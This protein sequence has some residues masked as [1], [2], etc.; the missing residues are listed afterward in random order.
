MSLIYSE[1]KI[2]LSNILSDEYFLKI[3]LFIRFITHT[4]P[5]AGHL[6]FIVFTY[7]LISW[8]HGIHIPS[9]S[10]DMFYWSVYNAEYKAG[11]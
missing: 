2:L 6:I 1:F 8:I 11:D 3:L 4:F 7:V 9:A 10:L 5:K